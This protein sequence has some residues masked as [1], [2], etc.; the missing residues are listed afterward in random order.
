MSIVWNS[1]QYVRESIKEIYDAATANEFAFGTEGTTSSLYANINV[2]DNDEAVAAFMS[3]AKF[4][5]GEFVNGSMLFD[6][7]GTYWTKGEDAVW[8]QSTADGNAKKVVAKMTND[9]IVTAK[10]KT[11]GQSDIRFFSD[12]TN[13][14]DFMTS[15]FGSYIFMATQAGW[16]SEALMGAKDNQ[17]LFLN[18][19]LSTVENSD[20]WLDIMFVRSQDTFSIYVCEYL[21]AEG[22]AATYDNWTLMFSITADGTE[23][24]GEGFSQ[25]S[26]NNWNNNIA[27]FKTFLSKADAALVFMSRS[28][29]GTYK[30]NVVDDDAAV[31]AFMA[32]EKAV[33]DYAK[34]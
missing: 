14:L 25:W 30:V 6:S 15:N 8:T 26:A 13:Y 23:T 18:E 1:A 28:G 21:D 16:W 2:E 32:S 17:P 12:S 9:F 20:G 27:G 10:I 33:A 11:T 34:A 29:V 31:A 3:T 19:T 4:T 5:S 22:K 24:W 7:N